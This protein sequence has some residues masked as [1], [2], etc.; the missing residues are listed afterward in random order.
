[1]NMFTTSNKNDEL[2]ELK[3]QKVESFR[4]YHARLISDLG[5]DRMD[6]NVKMPFYDR[7]GRNVVGI[8]AS[9]FKKANGFYFE[10]ITRDLS[11]L[12]PER[13]VYRAPNNPAFEEEYEMNEKFSYLVPIE[14][15]RIVN[16][17]S[18][19]I[20]GPSAVVT[21]KL[22][23]KTMTSYKAPAPIE[24]APYGEM[25]IRD[26]MAIHTGRPVST[27]TWLNDLIRNNR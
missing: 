3:R 9:E 5:I 16:P 10:L 19:A 25:T 8:F 1:M 12:D 23:N 20:S 22:S 26:Y 27:K 14:E 24:D 6:F 13:T 4:N 18:V 2:K 11:P 7:Q 17:T 15:L 21:E